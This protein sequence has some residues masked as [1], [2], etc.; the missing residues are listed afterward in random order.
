[1]EAQSVVV[2]DD[3]TASLIKRGT[4]CTLTLFEAELHDPEHGTY[5]PAKSISIT[6]LR[7]LIQLRDLLNQA[8][9]EGR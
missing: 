7:G 1:M 9:L 5:I 2:T 8:N 6:N 4:A 3:Q